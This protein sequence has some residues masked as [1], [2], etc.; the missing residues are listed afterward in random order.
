MLAV[1]TS[2]G[3]LTLPK[4]IRDRLG[5]SAG[6]RLDFQVNE[7]GWLLAR[8]VTNTALGLAGLLRRPG[9][10]AVSVEDMNEAVLATAAQL[11]P[12][13]AGVKPV[14]KAAPKSAGPA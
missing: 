14:P 10:V 13:P 7:Q 9:Q 8:P 11:N 6:S 5:L 4:G 1:L 3:Q 2:K 12:R